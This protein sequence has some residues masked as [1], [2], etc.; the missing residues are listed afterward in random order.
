VST[1][2]GLRSQDEVR[3]PGELVVRVGTVADAAAFAALRRRWGGTSEA[4][5]DLEQRIA[6]FLAA[7]GER[8]T[9]WLAE[10]DDQAV[11]MVSLFEYRRMPWPGR[12]D[13]RWGYV[14]NMFVREDC[15]R[16]GIGAALIA[17][18]VETAEQR[19]YA[20]LVVSPSPDA[21]ALYHGAGF[22]PAD[23]DGDAGE[24]LLARTGRG[25]R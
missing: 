12:S 14:G 5:D 2:D 16:R 23:G 9:T 3:R 21:L 11:G 6:A 19:A 20:R 22:V 18:L 15:R 7:E 25:G 10:L 17:R 1:D 4:D 8:R 24:L 13:S